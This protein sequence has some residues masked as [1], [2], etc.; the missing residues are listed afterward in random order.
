MSM[1]IIKRLIVTYHPDCCILH[2]VGDRYDAPTTESL[3]QD[4]R[5]RTSGHRTLIESQYAV[6]SLVKIP[7]WK[8]FISSP[9]NKE[10][11]LEFLSVSW[12]E[13]TTCSSEIRLDLYLGGMHKD[14]GDTWAFTNRE[15]NTV[16]DLSCEKHEE[17]DTRMMAHLYYCSQELECERIIVESEDTDVLLLS[18]FHFAR[19]KR[20]CE[21]FVRRGGRYVHVHTVVRR[22][23]EKCNVSMQ[24]ITAALLSGF[25]L[26]GCDTFEP[27]SVLL[28]VFTFL[29][30]LIPALSVNAISL[31]SFG[32][33]SGD[34]DNNAQVLRRQKKNPASL[35]TTGIVT[36][37]NEESGIAEDPVNVQPQTP[38][39]DQTSESSALKKA[40]ASP[41]S[42]EA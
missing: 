10:S 37:A 13:S 25:A 16:K 36:R 15:W 30:L 8:M 14:S 40:S 3:K 22:L 35:S 9:Q 4:E 31:A 28:P 18:M 12:M 1:N 23:A 6:A 2:I 34:E 17:A 41:A 27:S 20:F 7:D 26:T 32:S 5:V 24:T 38:S 11:L 39:T 42:N 33:T 19:L 29:C 21:I